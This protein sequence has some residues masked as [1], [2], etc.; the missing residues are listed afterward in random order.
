MNVH[1]GKIIKEIIKDHDNVKIVK[2]IEDR[3][4]DWEKVTALY[5]FIKDQIPFDWWVIADIDELEENEIKQKTNQF[6]TKYQKTKNMSDKKIKTN[7]LCHHLKV[8]VLR[9]PLYM[10]TTEQ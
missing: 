5:N 10:S 1:K 4:F 8:S 6:I 9:Y 7:I 3:V 2:I